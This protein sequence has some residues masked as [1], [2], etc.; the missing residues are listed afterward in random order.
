MVNESW[1]NPSDW[2]ETNIIYQT[3]FYQNLIKKKFI[4]KIIHFSTPE[5]Y[6]STK[7]I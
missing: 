4:K 3:K 1:I 6:G 7:K 2:Y 5:V